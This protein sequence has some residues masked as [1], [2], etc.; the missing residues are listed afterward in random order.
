MSH[1]FNASTA[2]S[3]VGSSLKNAKTTV[4]LAMYRPSVAGCSPPTGTKRKTTSDTV[5]RSRGSSR[6]PSYARGPLRVRACA[7]I[8][9]PVCVTFNYR[10]RA[11][12]PSLRMKTPDPLGPPHECPQTGGLI[13]LRSDRR[14]ARH[15][16][17]PCLSAV[18]PDRD[19]AAQFLRRRRGA[20]RKGQGAGG[21][22][23]DDVEDAGTTSCAGNTPPVRCAAAR[24]RRI[25]RRRRRS[26]QHDRDLCRDAAGDRELALGRRAVLSAHRQVADPAHAPR[27][28]SS[29][30]GY[31]SRCSAIRRWTS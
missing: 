23:A 31:R 24:S 9:D 7:P 1:D 28:R 12:R 25:G 16:A 6:R 11:R 29:S 26:R 10:E 13:L 15:G 5:R 2:S 18:E 4:L 3:A 14:A 8:A 20:H 22:G 19:G 30:S 21:A 27:S 17:E